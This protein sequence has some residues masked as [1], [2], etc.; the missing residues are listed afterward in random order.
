MKRATMVLA[1]SAVVLAGLGEARAE[2]AAAPGGSA[3]EQWAKSLS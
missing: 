3:L 2:E 1:M